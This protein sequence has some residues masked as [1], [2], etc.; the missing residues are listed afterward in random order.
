MSQLGAQNAMALDG[1]GSSGLSFR[2][3]ISLESVG[4]DRPIAAAL[5][6]LP[7]K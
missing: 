4:G 6:L 3:G 2:K 1:G 7:K 5:I